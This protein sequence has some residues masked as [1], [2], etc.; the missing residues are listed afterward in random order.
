M[1]CQSLILVTVFTILSI[2]TCYPSQFY[3]FGS[4]AGDSELPANDDGST[5]SIPIAVSF[6]FFGS[7]YNSIFVNNN[8]DITFERPLR[9]YTSEP[10]PINGTHKIIAPFWTDIDTT[11]GG[12]LWYRTTTDYNTMGQGTRKICSLFPNIGTFL[13]TWM[14]IMTWDNVAMYQCSSS[15]SIS[16]Q[17]RNTFQLVLITDGVH[18]FAVFN[19]HKVTWTKSTQVGFN[20]GDGV[21]FFSVP[22][23]MTDTVLNLPQMS[24]IMIP[25]QFVFRVDQAKITNADVINECNSS[26]C[27]HGRCSNEYLRYECICD[28]GYSGVNCETDIDECASSPCVHGACADRINGY[29]CNC[30]PGYSGIHCEIDI[31]ECASSPCIHGNCTDLVNGYTCQCL[32]GY[33]GIVC[34]TDIDECL[35]SPCKHGICIDKVNEY[36]CVCETG[37]YGRQCSDN[38]KFYVNRTVLTSKVNN[39]GDVTFETPLRQYTSQPF[40][41][42]GSHRIIAPFWTDIDTRQGGKLWYRTTTDTAVLERGTTKINS[43]FPDILNFTATWMMIITWEDVAAFGCSATGAITCQQVGFNAGDGENYYSVPGSMTNAVLNL[44][45]MSNIGI[46]GQFVFRVDQSKITNA[47]MDECASSPCVHGSC[48]D[49]VTGFVCSCLSGYTGINCEV[50]FLVVDFPDF[51][52]KSLKS[53]DPNKS[54]TRSS[55]MSYP[56]FALVIVSAVLNI[57]SGYS[58]S[59]FY[60]FG[61]AAGDSELP[62]NDDNSTSRIP[63]VVSFPF[64]G[65][66]YN[67][68]YVNNNGDTTFET[69]LRQFTSQPFPINGSHRIIAPFWTDIDTRQGGK[70]WYRITTDTTILQRGTNKIN[71]LFP[72]IVTFTATWMMIIT[73][74]DVAAYSCSPTGTI[75]C[76]Q[77]GFNAGDGE[78]YYSVPGSMTDAVLNLS[79]MSNIGIP[80]QFV[81]RVDQAKITNADIV[82]ECASS[83]CVHGNCSNEYLYYECICDPGYTGVNCENEIDECQSS[84]CIHGNC[85]DHLNHYTCH[86]LDGYTGINCQTDINEC[87]SSPCVYGNCTDHIN[88]YVCNCMPGYSGIHC[89]VDINE[90]QSSPCVHGNCSDHVNHYTCQCYAGFTGTNCQIDIDE[91]ASSP[92][93]HG[94]CT[95]Q[96]NGYTC[97]CIPGY[98]GVICETEIDECSSSPCKHGLCIDEINNYICVCDTAY[99]GRD[100]SQFNFSY[101]IPFLVGLLLLVFALVL[102]LLWKRIKRDSESEMFGVINFSDTPLGPSKTSFGKQT[103]SFSTYFNFLGFINQLWQRIT[104][105]TKPSGKINAISSNTPKN[106][107]RFTDNSAFQASNIY[108]IHVDLPKSLNVCEID[109]T[110]H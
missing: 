87:A 29:V 104:N 107:Q 57:C 86:C 82:D 25:G 61:L 92:C 64:F 18:S 22:G 106:T 68:I 52:Y 59:Q 31:N 72:D 90:C 11:E 33:T 96:V 49:G 1:F 70:L 46:P 83:P 16:C 66:S 89:E 26:P 65:S 53:T 20:A 35:S 39:N 21:N 81:F 51:L 63:I 54:K 80:G 44:P 67:S 37:Y 42:N 95:D 9:Q 36:R 4:G 76:Q 109:G 19:Y 8:G 94:N 40:P 103:Q 48:T 3:S 45:Q 34:E 28:Q 102:L 55:T 14:M 24:N 50:V 60:S 56:T 62:A 77:V 13:A 97:E 58:L 43:F 105:L 15:G 71:S 12:K 99:Y 73:W 110:K 10:F 78:N 2:C 6:P 88:G 30:I 84:P 27:V 108:Y 100:C 41:I 93:I 85:S 47:D 32:L 74:E 17:Q 79:Q 75:N 7:T 101:L 38:T 69:P 23:S 91:C 5:P 98:T